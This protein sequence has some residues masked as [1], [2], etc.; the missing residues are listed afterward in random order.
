[1]SERQVKGSTKA[2]SNKCDIQDKGLR[3]VFSNVSVCNQRFCK[4]VV[5]NGVVNFI[6]DSHAISTQV[7]QR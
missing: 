7:C 4:G 2:S 3:K 1:M 5:T 6:C